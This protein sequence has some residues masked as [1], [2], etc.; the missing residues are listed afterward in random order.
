MS[1]LKPSVAEEFAEHIAYHRPLAE[2]EETAAAM[3]SSPSDAGIVE[4]IV[5]RR[6]SMSE[7]FSR[8]ACLTRRMG[9]G[10]IVGR[11]GESALR[12]AAPIRSGRSL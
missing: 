8:K 3:G 5:C 2:I 7:G 11:I 12:P 1:T 10:E 9:F 6:P 4:M